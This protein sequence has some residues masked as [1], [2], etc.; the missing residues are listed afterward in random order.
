VLVVTDRG[1]PCGARLSSGKSCRGEGGVQ[2][3]AYVLDGK[4]EFK[5][6][7]PGVVGLLSEKAEAFEKIQRVATY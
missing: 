2:T 7:I 5:I 6:C 1:L 3:S 4:F